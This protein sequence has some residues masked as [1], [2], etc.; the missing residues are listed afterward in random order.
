MAKTT[1]RIS[2]AKPYVERALRDEDLRD[3]VLNAFQ[4][5][6]EVYN[7][8]IGD[9]GVTT[10]ATRVATDKDIQDKLKEALDE[11]REATDRVQ[12][13]K[14][15]GGRNAT[16][17]IAGIALGVLFNPMTGP[18]TRRWLKDRIFGSDDSFGGGS[19]SGGG[20]SGG[21]SNS[22]NAA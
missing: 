6:R 21:S 20:E 4:A 8:L 9:R 22:G 10:L 3:N 1:E 5:A 13:K 14:D 16:L 2:D 15:H 17:L 19:Y 7:E 12:G 18:E 11:L